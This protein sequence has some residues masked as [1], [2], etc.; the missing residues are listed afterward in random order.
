MS[1]DP[2][3]NILR[4]L[5]DDLTSRVYCII[6]SSK[7]ILRTDLEQKL[8]ELRFYDLQNL[9]SAIAKLE[10][11]NF[12][13]SI[14]EKAERPSGDAPILFKER[15]HGKVDIYKFNNININLLS[16]KYN[17]MKKSLK[18]NLKE[19]GDKKYFC[20]KCNEQTNENFASRNNY[21]CR[22]CGR[23]YEK[24]SEDI[25]D[26]NKKCEMIFEVLDELF[27]EEESN[28]STGINSFYKNYLSSKYGKNYYNDNK[29]KDTFEE[30]HDSYLYETLEYVEHLNENE[31]KNKLIFYELVEGYIRA[32]KK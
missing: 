32:K 12:I 21:K 2:I 28:A 7:K 29:I 19:R 10:K 16:K 5:Y 22:N 8:K 15:G 26:I 9:D 18:N 23:D 25:A 3:K 13:T 17:E 20:P 14:R 31:K 4:I 11:E 27:K 30:D 1:S 24:A 6:K